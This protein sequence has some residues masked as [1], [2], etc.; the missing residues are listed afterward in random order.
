METELIYI[1]TP[2][3]SPDPRVQ[4]ERFKTVNKVS[5][6]LMEKGKYVFSPISHTHPIAIEGDLPK[7]WDYWEGYDR[8]MLSKCT[9][10]LVVMADGWQESIGVKAEI[11]IAKELNI[12]IEYMEV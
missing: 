3:S 1:A 9:K 10:L 12:P 5:A 4:W 7:D 8:L 6:E 2:Y 11:G